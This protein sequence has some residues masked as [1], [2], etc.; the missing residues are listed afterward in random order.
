[1]TLYCPYDFDGP[2]DYTYERRD[3]EVMS[4]E[5]ERCKSCKK[6][7]QIDDEVR[8]IAIMQWD[9]EVDD[10]VEVRRE[11][12]CSDCA[13]ILDT[14]EEI[15]YCAYSEDKPAKEV[16]EDYWEITDF[17]PERYRN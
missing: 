5:G 1:M 14:L 3:I 4:I 9:D 12:Y 17:D 16:L 2:Y 6:E 13:E 8:P 7:L 15:G 11:Y 10:N